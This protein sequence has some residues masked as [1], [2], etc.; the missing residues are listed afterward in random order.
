MEENRKR[1]ILLIDDDLRL[2]A[3]ILDFFLPYGFA[4][5]ALPSG[6]QVEEALL[7]FSP[8]I[9]LLDVML[10]GED[11]FSILKRIRSAH[12]TPLIMLTARG[13]DTDRIVGLEMGA[14]DYL[15]KPFNPRELLAR[16]KAVLRRAASEPAESPA[17]VKKQL[18]SGGVC[19]DLSRQT[20]SYKDENFRLSTTEFKLV[21]VFMSNTGVPL[22]REKLLNLAFG[23][24]YFVSDRNIDVHISRIRSLLV[25]LG[26]EKNTIRTVWNTGYCWVG[27]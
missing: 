12:S 7:K 14:D 5:E 3:V 22:S 10:P 8:D 16:I 11:G 15:P 6:E 21:K 4:V 25:K 13:E 9:I 18:C 2:Q 1:K 23:K 24:D 20:L 27:E 26:V 17:P 19:L